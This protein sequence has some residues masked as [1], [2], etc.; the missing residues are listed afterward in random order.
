MKDW[1]TWYVVF[2]PVSLGS[3]SPLQVCHFNFSGRWIRRA[4]PSSWFSNFIA[5]D[6]FSVADVPLT[7]SSP[8]LA[9]SALLADTFGASG[10][11]LV[12]PPQD[13]KGSHQVCPN[14][15]SFNGLT[16]GPG[17]LGLIC[18]VLVAD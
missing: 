12:S 6:G 9:L 5:A 17:L 4:V 15:F 2:F 1:D 13:S 14:V 11:T 18:L 8:M 16:G 3:A 7:T 10:A